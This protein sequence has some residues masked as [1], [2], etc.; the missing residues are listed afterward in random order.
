MADRSLMFCKFQVKCE[1]LVFEKEDVVHGLIELI[2]LHRV[3]RLV[4]SAATDRQYS[5]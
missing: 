1:K 3:T 4:M 2:V 5:R